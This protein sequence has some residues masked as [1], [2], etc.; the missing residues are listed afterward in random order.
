MNTFKNQITKWNKLKKEGKPLPIKFGVSVVL[1]LAH[2][3]KWKD[4]M[5][6]FCAS[7]GIDFSVN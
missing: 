7:N 6:D 3:D 1:F 2:T 4:R 5:T